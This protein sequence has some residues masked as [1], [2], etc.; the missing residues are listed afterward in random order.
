MA[1]HETFWVA[2]AAAAPIIAL[3]NQVTLNDLPEMRAIFKFAQDTSPP[4]EAHDIAKS[5]HRTATRLYVA[6][7]LI[8]CVQAVLLFVALGSLAYGTDRYSPLVVTFGEGLGLLA[9]GA[10]TIYFG[11]VR[12]AQGVLDAVGVTRSS[13]NDDEAKNVQTDDGDG[14]HV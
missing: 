11:G 5:G 4:G 9:V 2:A 3:A 13:S 8:L 10:T 12:V 7:T 6:G 1:F 14:Y